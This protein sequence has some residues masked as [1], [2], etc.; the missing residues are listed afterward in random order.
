MTALLS[1]LRARTPRLLDHLAALVTVESP[2]LDLTAT[3]AAADA[4]DDLVASLLGSRCER[5]DDGG[6]VHL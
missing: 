4:A 5:Y 1:E 2:S 3:A 6:R